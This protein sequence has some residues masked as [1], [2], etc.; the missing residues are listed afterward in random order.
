MLLY[1]CT[2]VQARQV[3]L[4]LTRQRVQPGWQ[5]SKVLSP[6]TAARGPLVGKAAAG[7][8]PS[9]LGGVVGV[10]GVE[11]EGGVAVPGL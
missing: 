7:G 9:G 4:S 5:P 2:S 1:A 8:G 11:L 10:G 6:G 3:L